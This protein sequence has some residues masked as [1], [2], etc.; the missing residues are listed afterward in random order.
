M[1]LFSEF[2]ATDIDSL[3]ESVVFKASEIDSKLKS[4]VFKV[5]E[6]VLRGVAESICGE[7]TSTALVAGNRTEDRGLHA[8]DERRLIDIP[9]VGYFIGC[10]QEELRG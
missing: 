6:N 3:V 2:N 1:H 7:Q 5:F 9:S 10:K 8:F 4:V